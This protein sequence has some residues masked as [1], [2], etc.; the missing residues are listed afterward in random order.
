MEVKKTIALANGNEIPVIGAGFWQV[1]KEDAAFTAE[2]SLKLG[3]R[4]LDGAAAY[5]NEVEMGAGIRASGIARDEI[6][7]T[8]KVPAEF[9]SYDKAYKSIEDSYQRI[10]CGP[11]DLILIHCPVPWALFGLP[12][13]YNKES[14]EVW[15]AFEDAYEA[16]LV[17]A[18][19]VSN[20]SIRELQNIIDHCKVKPMVNQFN[21]HIGEANLPLIEFC[22]KEG[23]AVEA[24][25]PLGT[26]RIFGDKD[27]E[28]MAEKY[29]VTVAQLAIRYTL[30][31]GAITLPKSVHEERLKQNMDV[32]GFDISEA[33]MEI[34]NKRTNPKRMLYRK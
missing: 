25:S 17:K 4:L 31:L 34:L 10:G 5:R 11:I 21:I 13:G 23:I 6:F 3:Y 22:H 12:H 15:K 26:G 27:L 19:G 32:F 18:I 9:K 24:Y 14:I 29:G 1:K 2:T 30:Q 16:G 33:D 7:I 28:A 8:T 20:F